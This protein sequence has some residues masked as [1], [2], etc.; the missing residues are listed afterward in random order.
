M[1]EIHRGP[2][3]VSTVQNRQVGENYLQLVAQLRDDLEDAGSAYTVADNNRG[4]VERVDRTVVAAQ[5]ATSADPEAGELL[6]DAW[7]H[8]YGLRPDPDAAYDDAIRAVEQI[9]CPDV[10]PK[11]PGSAT[12]GKVIAHFKQGGHKWQFV[13]LN[14]DGNGTVG[15]VHQREI[16]GTRRRSS[17]GPLS[18]L[19]WC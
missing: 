4:L 6:A 2:G 15:K 17:V 3:W 1:L 11:E 5:E 12:F 9:A 16:S 8:A 13:L 10:L 14:D 18:A 19:R 7:N